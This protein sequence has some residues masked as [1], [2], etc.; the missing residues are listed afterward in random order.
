M[1]FPNSISNTKKSNVQI[2][3]FG[4]YLESSSV[5][6]SDVK[7]YTDQLDLGKPNLTFFSESNYFLNFPKKI[8]KYDDDTSSPTYP[9]NFYFV[10]QLISLDYSPIIM[11]PKIFSG[12]ILLTSYRQI[13]NGDGN[14]A[15]IVANSSDLDN[16]ES[17][18]I[19]SMVKIIA[20]KEDASIM[21]EK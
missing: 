20:E 10:R 16:N 8:K 6:N 4:V 3:T 12:N 7:I 1:S 13:I 21:S 14:L 15:W 18:S 19:W 17:Y 9:S 2:L 5:V 11:I